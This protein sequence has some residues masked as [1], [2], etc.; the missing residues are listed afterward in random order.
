M[1]NL[2]G[3]VQDERHSSVDGHWHGKLLLSAL[4]TQLI[5]SSENIENRCCSLKLE[6]TALLL[7]KSIPCVYFQHVNSREKHQQIAMHILL[8]ILAFFQCLQVV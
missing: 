8:H 5:Q 4:P 7:H 3:S 2:D 1:S 6:I